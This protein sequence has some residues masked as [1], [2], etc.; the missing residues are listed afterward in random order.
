MRGRVLYA[1]AE[2]FTNEFMAS[3]RGKRMEEFKRRFRN[4]CDMLVVEDV[5]FLGAKRA[6]QLELF[7]TLTHL[8]DVGA[9]VVLTSDRL[10][11][12][13]SGLDPR[14]GSQMAA[15]FV[16]EIERPDAQVRRR[17]LASKAAAGGVRLPDD[18]L[19]L[20]VER[21]RANVRDLIG[22]LTQLV[23][24]AALLKR[25]IDRELTRAALHKVAPEPGDA[26]HLDAKAVIQVVAAFFQKSPEALASRSR[27]RDVL[28]PRQLA[29]YLCRRYT[30]AS[31]GE[32]AKAFGR[33]H[34]AVNN[35][36]RVVELRM[37]EHAPLRYQ[38]EA[39]TERLDA[40]RRRSGGVSAG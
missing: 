5:Q 29:M 35:A 14:L 37:L 24:S 16:A 4:G 21:V 7:H 25:P 9:R 31:A 22:V 15:G 38:V 26:R 36:V 34:P 6:T 23:A 18:C 17:I 30:D 11:R 28:V 32:I 20:L 3:I 12:S 2:T 39:L 33:S 40:L 27:R 19:D 8:I 1:S 10:P 13:I